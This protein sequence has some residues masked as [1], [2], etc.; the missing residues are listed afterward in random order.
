MPPPPLGQLTRDIPASVSGVVEEID[1]G[2]LN[3][4]AMTAGAPQEKGAGIDLFKK[5]GDTVE[6]GEVLYRIYAAKATSFAFANG[7][8]EGNSGYKISA[9]G[10]SY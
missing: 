1:G 8:A 10:H 7:L 6:Q 3:R 5:V 4:I 9:K 2:Q